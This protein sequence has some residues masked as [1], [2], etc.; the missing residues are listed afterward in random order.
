MPRRKYGDTKKP[1]TP[2]PGNSPNEDKGKRKEVGESSSPSTS[3][4]VEPLKG[5]KRVIIYTVFEGIYMP[6]KDN[7]TVTSVMDLYMNQIAH[8]HRINFANVKQLLDEGTRLRPIS[9]GKV[10][11]ICVTL[12]ALGHIRTSFTTLL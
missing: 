3:S 4:K 1:T 5:P 7:D 10:P 11:K 9:Y 2:Y 12:P 6:V 8:R